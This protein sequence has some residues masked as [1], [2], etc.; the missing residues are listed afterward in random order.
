LIEQ[1]V[2][3]SSHRFEV[4]SVCNTEDL[5]ASDA[6]NIAFLKCQNIDLEQLQL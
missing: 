4:D 2:A 3:K 6:H 1:F 5:I